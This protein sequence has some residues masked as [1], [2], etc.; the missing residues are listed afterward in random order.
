MS[1]TRRQIDKI[2][3]ALSKQTPRGG[4]RK[5]VPL[6]T[7]AKE[8]GLSEELVNDAAVNGAGMLWGAMSMGTIY[9]YAEATRVFTV[10]RRF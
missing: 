5:D 1:A 3:D 10:W 4:S 7:V 2:A 9:T 6:A 8:A